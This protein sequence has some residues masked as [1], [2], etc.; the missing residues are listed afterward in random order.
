[1]K[2]I[3]KLASFVFVIIFTACSS[4]E[5][6]TND[7]KVE[8]TE[9][10]FSFS[11]EHYTSD[12]TL[13]RAATTSVTPQ[14]VDLGDGLQAEV[15]IEQDKESPQ[16]RATQ[17]ISDGHYTIYAID[18]TGTR[19]TG[20]NSK[21][22]GTISG[23]V[24]TKDAGTKLELTPGTYTF[25]CFNDA[26]T[27]NGTNL[28][29]ASDNDALIGTATE[30]I[31]GNA[32]HVNFLM[33]HQTARVR[34][35]FTGYTDQAVGV[36]AKFTFTSPQPVVNTYSVD[37]STI[38][39]TTGTSANSYTMPTTSTTFNTK[40]V[41]AHDF[42]TNYSY[43]LPDIPTADTKLTF[44]AGT[45]YG[46]ALTGK[47]FSL[48]KLSSLLF[49]RNHSYTVSI[50]LKT[51]LYLFEDGTVGVFAEKGSRT[52]IG[53]VANE[54]TNTEAGFACAL[55]YYQ[56]YEMG[57]TG[58]SY[59][60]NTGDHIKEN[61]GPS[62]TNMVEAA[63]DM[64]GYN[65]TYS[66]NLQG[67]VRAN[68]PVIYPAFY[69]AAHHNPGVTITGANV[70][71]WFLPAYGQLVKFAETLGFT[72]LTFTTDEEKWPHYKEGFS[73][74]LIDKLEQIVTAANPSVTIMRNHFFLASTQIIN[75]SEYRPMYLYFQDEAPS[76]TKIFTGTCWTT[77]SNSC[78][79][80][81]V[82]F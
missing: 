60:K 11:P 75:N 3:L 29:I 57:F 10:H 8:V 16:T 73:A 82:E 64:N 41:Q 49:E 71:K 15:N 46:K 23:G 5:I 63:T 14:V 79:L 37:A 12:E 18:A 38:T 2:K 39:P 24:F 35:R 48:S 45:I 50:K 13:T 81:F 65:W 19:V 6:A 62:P 36:T 20:T 51:I 70:G 69:L 30:T 47:S 80:P 56:K 40:Y 26:V 9:N 55:R 53:V 78:V 58:N 42:L 43:V 33:K 27:D 52:P 28:T 32:W 59:W 72:P 68:E 67:V 21:V 1:M 76:S 44:T 61:S 22:S 17:P 34:F 25:V 7:N 31:S 4:E 66:P 54:K 77:M 74:G